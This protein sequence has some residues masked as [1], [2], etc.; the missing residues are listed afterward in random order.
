MNWTFLC[1]RLEGLKS[2]TGYISTPGTGA[3][4]HIISVD[5]EAGRIVLMSERSRSGEPRVITTSQIRNAQGATTNGVILRTLLA[6]ASGGSSIAGEWH[7]PYKIRDLLEAAIDD[8]QD[9]P[10]DDGLVYLVTEQPWSQEAPD[11]NSLPLYLG[12]TTGEGG[13]FVTRIGDLIADLF[14]F[15]GTQTGHSSGGQAIYDYAYRAKFRPGDFY[16]SWL[17]DPDGCRRCAESEWHERL[18]PRLNKISPP[19]CSVHKRKNQT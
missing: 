19:K 1:D 3:R 7:G 11:E 13:R 6:L 5:R 4:N 10:P 15:Y 9:W 16:L 17:L 18:S 8:K 14:G 12:A 2:S